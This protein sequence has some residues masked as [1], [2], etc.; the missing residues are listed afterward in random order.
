MDGRDSCE[1]GARGNAM[2]V[3]FATNQQD[4]SRSPCSALSICR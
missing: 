1:A 2:F 3:D 4:F